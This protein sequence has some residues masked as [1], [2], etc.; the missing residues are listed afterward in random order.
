MRGFFLVLK[1]LLI[2]FGL[3]GAGK[4][5]V[6]E[7]LAKEFDYYFWDADKD[8]PE[9]MRVKILKKEL[10]TQDMRDELT[11]IMKDRIANLKNQYPNLVIAQALYKK[12][13]RQ[14]IVSHFPETRFIWI[15]ATQENIHHRLHQRNNSIDLAY[16]EKLS[17]HFEPPDN[18]DAI[19]VNDSDRT[20][21]ISQLQAYL[22]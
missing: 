18:P 2:L 12:K 20:A 11:D 17:L 14:Q 3:S 6:G 15:K 5:F 4:N 7:I 10:F 22:N 9:A 19:I 16:A 13:N 8:L 21:V 1:M